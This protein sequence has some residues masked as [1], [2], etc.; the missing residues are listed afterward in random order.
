M[1]TVGRHPC[2]GAY[3]DG[4]YDIP[5]Y[6]NIQYP[7]DGREDV[8]R[9]AVPT[10]FNPVASYVKYFTLPEKF[11]KNGL[12]ISFQGVESGFCAL[13]ERKLCRLQ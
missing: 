12:Y 11:V 10:D 6:A 9:D 13:A 8:W 3:P 5:Q 2:A 1:Q 7:W 4:G